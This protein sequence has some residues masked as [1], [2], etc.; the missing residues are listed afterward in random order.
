[1]VLLRDDW[2]L[3]VLT[4]AMDYSTNCDEF[5]PEWDSGRWVPSW[6][7]VTGSMPVRVGL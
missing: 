3:R 5:I 7:K 6:R 1:M 2:I 4:S